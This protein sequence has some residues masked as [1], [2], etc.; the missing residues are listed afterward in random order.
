MGDGL[1]GDPSRRHAEA[2]LGEREPGVD[3]HRLLELFH[4]AIEVGGVNRDLAV[5]IVSVGFHGARELG[6]GRGRLRRR[7]VRL[8]LDACPALELFPDPLAERIG[9]NEQIVGARDPRSLGRDRFARRHV[10]ELHRRHQALARDDH[11][12]HH[13]GVDFR[14]L[15]DAGRDRSIQPFGAETALAGDIVEPLLAHETNPRILPRF[16]LSRSSVSMRPV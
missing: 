7:D 9:E 11:L 2:E 3:A 1:V 14:G 15:R 5:D 8:G 12:P 6:A 16:S 13:H 10:H 4:R